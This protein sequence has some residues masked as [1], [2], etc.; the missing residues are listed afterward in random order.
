[1]RAVFELRG[2]KD[3]SLVVAA[4]L[5]AID[6]QPANVRGAEARA[7][8]PRLDDKLAP[9][10]L[11]SALRS[12]LAK[13]GSALDAAAPL[14]LRALHATA[15]PAS[16][17]PLLNAA[18]A[19]A[20][21]IGLP[22]MRVLVSPQLGRACVPA[23]SE[24][25]TLVVGEALL[26]V[27]NER[28]RAFMVVRAL[29]LIHAHASALVRTPAAEL[30]ILVSAWLQYFNPTWTPP[31]VN[32]AMLAAAAKRLSGALPRNA[33]PDVAVMALEVAG[34][35]GTQ[36]SGLGTSALAWANRAALLAIGD[37]NAALDAIAWSHGAKDAA[38]TDPQERAT[39]IGR[40]HEAKD[41]LT[42]SVSDAYAEVRARLSM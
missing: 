11:S 17:A 19:V 8:D 13:T 7:L 36:A 30:G 22:G 9:D 29:K 28:A 18:S 26:G 5:A 3:A 37:P 14:D 27:T 2:K 40:T 23:S 21:A 16:A 6:G 12:L 39:W 4:T 10:V 35:I 25:P 33:P 20:S 42:Y 1:M 31:G 38:P 15:P 24:P 32:P 34:S 41:L